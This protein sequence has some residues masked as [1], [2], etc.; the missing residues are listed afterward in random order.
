MSTVES[1]IPAY[2]RVADPRPIRPPATYVPAVDAFVA[3]FPRSIASITCGY[4]GVQVEGEPTNAAADALTSIV[5][6]LKREDAPDSY[7]LA[8]TVDAEG[9][10]TRIA[11]AYWTSSAKYE[12]WWERERRAVLGLDD[13]SQDVGRFAEVVA[14]TL[15]RF[16]TMFSSTTRPEGAARVGI[17]GMSCPV[18]E[19]GYW[20]G[21]R[22]RIPL[23]QTDDLV[24]PP[25]L[26]AAR[27]TADGT[28]VVGAHENLAVI[29]SGQD[30]ADCPAAEVGEYLDD[31]E[32]HLRAGMDF[33]ENDGL[34]IGCFT[35]RYL[36]VLDDAGNPSARTFGYSCWRDL[37]DMET[38]AES[39]P[40]HLAIFDAGIALSSRK[41]GSHLRLYHEVYVAD[42]SQQHFEYVG[43]HPRTGMLNAAVLETIAVT[44]QCGANQTVEGELNV[45]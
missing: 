32:P 39:H 3:R 9:F 40:S 2:L 36:R 4:F 18:R 6:A 34:E 20:G 25:T 37:S 11:I 41:D 44:D 42:S 43:C 35:N 30:W 1:A 31:V 15:N 22:D 10:H 14:P 33:L 29:R 17:E 45:F 12:R 13:P 8:E 27:M 23:S 38:W 5:D 26:P 19:H 16:E 21:M 24:A 7:D 28:V